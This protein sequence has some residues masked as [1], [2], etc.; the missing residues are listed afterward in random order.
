[1]KPIWTV[2]NGITDKSRTANHRYLPLGARVLVK[3]QEN[4][5]SVWVTVTGRP[6]NSQ[7]DVIQLNNYVYFALA[8]SK[9]RRTLEG[10]ISYTTP[11]D[12]LLKVLP[13]Q[14][15][16]EQITTHY[17]LAKE[18]QLYQSAEAQQHIYEVIKITRELG[19]MEAEARAWLFLGD[20]QM[21]AVE[22]DILAYSWSLHYPNTPE[23]VI[24]K[25]A[26]ETGHKQADIIRWNRFGGNF[27]YLQSMFRFSEDVVTYP[28][29]KQISDS[30]YQH[31]LRIREAQNDQGKIVW[32]LMKL[33]DLH[34]IR[35]GYAE[36]EPY[37]LRILKI[38]EAEKSDEKHS[39]IWG[40]LAEFYWEQGN[41]SETEKYFQKLYGLREKNEIMDPKRLIWVMGGLRNLRY[42]Q[43]QIIEAIDIQSKMFPL[44][45]KVEKRSR[46]YTL[47]NLI[48]D[49][50]LVFQSERKAVLTALED[51]YT[52]NT[53]ETDEKAVLA[54]RL[55][56]AYAEDKDYKKAVQYTQDL[57][58]NTTDDK[59]RIQRLNDIAFYYQQDKSWS[60]AQDYYNQALAICSEKKQLDL[61]GIQLY[62][63]AYFYHVQ[64]NEKKS[65]KLLT[66]ALN[67]IKKLP[68]G[69][70]KNHNT[71]SQLTAI[72]DSPI[73]TKEWKIALAEECLRVNTDRWVK[74]IL[75]GKLDELKK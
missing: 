23:K 21:E 61:V 49:Y 73:G 33:G 18:L 74:Y 39:W 34:R 12:S 67:Q 13:T 28:N 38:R 11:I 57:L 3:N 63:L 54:Q 66:K 52:N 45:Q 16:I 36:A 51:W 71:M 14:S 59:Q 58:A 30:A 68:N 27:Y 40:Y 29:P 17:Q 65:D 62:K 37:Y 64:K 75:K 53:N 8:E 41:Y 44:Y 19:D 46:K 5:L 22:K 31:Y 26:A 9:S 56:Q 1:M 6:K 60:E 15:E 43:G 4:N 24:K 20:A 2:N 32:G 48:D 55:A 50:F 42:T 7:Q 72:L 69:S 70:L 35:S 25:I 10:S 47:N